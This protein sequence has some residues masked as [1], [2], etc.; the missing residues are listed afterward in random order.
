MTLVHTAARQPV[1]GEALEVELDMLEI[2]FRHESSGAL[3]T[4]EQFMTVLASIRAMQIRASYYTLV[5]TV[6]LLDIHL[7]MAAA[8]GTGSLARNVEMCTCP[9]N[10]RGSSCEVR[11]ATSGILSIF[12]VFLLMPVYAHVIQ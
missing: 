6:S 9:P 12:K 8:N 10:Y 11:D 3:V 5:D 2:Q 1:P 4:R 7:D